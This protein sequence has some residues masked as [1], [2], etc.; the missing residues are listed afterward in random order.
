MTVN[1]QGYAALKCKSGTLRRFRNPHIL[2]NYPW[3]HCVSV[4]VFTTPIHYFLFNHPCNH[5]VSFVVSVVVLTTFTHLHCTMPVLLR[6]YV[7]N[8]NN[9]FHTSFQFSFICDVLHFL[10]DAYMPMTSVS[11]DFLQQHFFLIE[12]ALYKQQNVFHIN[13]QK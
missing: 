1:S 9:R 5:C 7:D 11:N 4:V 2:F 13:F 12:F 6:K 3:N 8:A 10:F